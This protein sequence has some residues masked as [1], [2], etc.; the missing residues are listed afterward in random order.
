MLVASLGGLYLPHVRQR[1]VSKFVTNAGAMSLAA[2]GASL[3]SNLHAPSAPSGVITATASITL[4]TLS[5]WV[6]NN[7]VVAI[8]VTV[9]GGPSVQSSF[10][11]LV[12]SDASVLVLC[13]AASAIVVLADERP[14]VQ[15]SGLAACVAASALTSQQ[16]FGRL[17]TRLWN[18][19]SFACELGCW[20]TATIALWN[21]GA[22][23]SQVGVLLGSGLGYALWSRVHSPIVN[24][25]GA[26]AAALWMG[27]LLGPPTSVFAA[28][29]GFGLLLTTPL[30]P[31][32]LRSTCV[33]TSLLVLNATIAAAPAERAVGGGAAMACVVCGALLPQLLA[34]L[35]LLRSGG[36][37]AATLVGMG[38][39][40]RWDAATALGGSLVLAAFCVDLRVGLIAT[41]TCLVPIARL[42]RP[43]S[44]RYPRS[45][46]G[47]SR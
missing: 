43:G 12:S 17:L 27:G 22:P 39:P 44:V 4:A 6:I 46:A 40:S 32:S 34:V 29:V 2:L 30:G 28:I 5:Y 18:R 35:R 13:S 7:A 25:V 15:L 47:A 31:S 14:L 45:G 38:V 26:A 9:R 10:R 19:H 41:L 37:S 24:T 16:R 42:N 33:L 8:Y 23:P 36:G 11:T 3:A 1:D 21:A 20:V